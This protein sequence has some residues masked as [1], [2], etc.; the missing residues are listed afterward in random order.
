LFSDLNFDQF[1]QITAAFSPS[2]SNQAMP[3][4][5]KIPDLS[6]NQLLTS[7]QQ[8]AD[9]AAGKITARTHQLKSAAK[10]SIASSLLFFIT[11]CSTTTQDP[12]KSPPSM[13]W[14][15]GNFHVRFQAGPRGELASSFSFYEVT[16]APADEEKEIIVRGSA[17]TNDSL[18]C[19]SNGHPNDFIRIIEDPSGKAILIEEEIPNDCGAITNYLWIHQDKVGDM[20]QGDYLQLPDEPAAP[21]EEAEN[22]C[23]KVEM[24]DGDILRY[25]HS[26]GSRFTRRISEIEKTKRPTMP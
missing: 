5:D 16:Y 23:P 24:I 19:V 18:G 7:M 26:T 6:F 10:F 17:L 14:N 9:H 3:Q 15:K 20:L 11:A 4:K 1:K 8:G 22:D 25:R 13:E 2:Q 21:Y 12:Q